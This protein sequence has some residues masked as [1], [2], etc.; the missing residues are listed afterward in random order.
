MS[1]RRPGPVLHVAVGRGALRANP[2]DTNNS[3]TC[4]L[5]GPTGQVRWWGHASRTIVLIW[6]LDD[7][8]AYSVN[9]V[10]KGCQQVVQTWLLALLRF[11][12]ACQF[13]V[14][15]FNLL[16]FVD[17]GSRWP[18]GVRGVLPL[19]HRGLP[20]GQPGW[21]AERADDE[22]ADVRLAPWGRRVVPLPCSGHQ[23]PPE[24]L[25]CAADPCDL[26]RAE[27]ITDVVCGAGPDR[28]HPF[29]DLGTAPM[30]NCR[31]LS[32]RMTC[33]CSH[34]QMSP[35]IPWTKKADDDGG[36]RARWPVLTD[37]VVDDCGKGCD[38]VFAQGPRRCVEHI[39]GV[40]QSAPLLRRLRIVNVGDAEAARFVAALGHRRSS[41]LRPVEVGFGGTSNQLLHIV[42]GID[43]TTGRVKSEHPFAQR[44]FLLT[45][46]ACLDSPNAV[47]KALVSLYQEDSMR[48]DATALVFVQ[49]C[50]QTDQEKRLLPADEERMLAVFPSLPF[51][52]HANNGR[53]PELA[54]DF[55]NPGIAVGQ[56][57]PLLFG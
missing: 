23:L 16:A 1:N 40:I 35:A 10:Y 25:L 48:A 52:H 39:A 17:L 28:P 37:L 47:V 6:D 55:R 57:C 4:L 53:R 3:R 50:T 22:R 7:V 13:V 26:S 41:C 12:P 18:K 46:I 19:V 56:P 33:G 45:E 21:L 31:S 24:C 9:S 42:M 11:V 15:A 36:G 27:C 49:V 14:A 30:Q 2:V 20:D 43:T 29:W 32:V 34:H 54:E 51:V 8:D 5:G 38:G 44:R